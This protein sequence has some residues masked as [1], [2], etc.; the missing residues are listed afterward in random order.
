MGNR[1]DVV[2]SCLYIEPETIEKFKSW[3]VANKITCNENMKYCY[4]SIE[5]GDPI[6]NHKYKYPIILNL[7]GF[8]IIGY[9]Y[10]EFKT[11]IK[12]LYDI[13]LKGEIELTCDDGTDAI[14]R[15]DTDGL[16]I[17]IRQP[18]E[19]QDYKLNEV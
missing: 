4:D 8:K 12:E 13:G 1:T 14:I 15:F 18:K 10:S 17:S 19:F 5:I 16:I 2:D 9:W 3:L 11:F 6:S 7:D